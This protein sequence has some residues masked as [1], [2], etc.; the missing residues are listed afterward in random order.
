MLNACVGMAPLVALGTPENGKI[1]GAL[2]AVSAGP[3]IW[4]AVAPAVRPDQ[5]SSTVICV[6]AAFSTTWPN[7]V[8]GEALGGFSEVPRRLASKVIW[9]E[10]IP[11]ENRI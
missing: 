5:F 11:V 4:E 9:A 10:A 1:T 3:W 6:W 8:P 2:W 7:P